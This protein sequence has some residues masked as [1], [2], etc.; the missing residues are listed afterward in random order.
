[1]PSSG[2][3]GPPRVWL[4]P[5]KN[6]QEIAQEHQWGHNP[7]ET[8]NTKQKPRNTNRG[9]RSNIAIQTRKTKRSIKRQVSRKD[10]RKYFSR[11]ETPLELTKI[12]NATETTEN[13]DK[14]NKDETHNNN[15]ATTYSQKLKYEVAGRVRREF[16]SRL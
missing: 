7:A 8:E 1:M 6:N 2:G 14:H 16:G 11:G 13:Q 4:K 5:I 10:S 15:K 9:I 3:A 12:K